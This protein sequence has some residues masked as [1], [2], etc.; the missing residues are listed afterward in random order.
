MNN[1]VWMPIK[2]EVFL[3][4]NTI[5]FKSKIYTDAK[6]RCNKM[7]RGGKIK[8]T[9]N[10]HSIGANERPMLLFVGLNDNTNHPKLHF[11]ISSNGDFSIA[12][13]ELTGWKKLASTEL[14]KIEL[15]HVETAQYDVEIEL[16]GSQACMYINGVLVCKTEQAKST[17]S[18]I[19]LNL[20]GEGKISIQKFDIETKRLSAFVIMDFSEEFEYIYSEVIK[21]V[22]K[23]LDIEC[24]RADEYNYPGSI[25]KDI[26]DSI[27]DSD[28]IIVD[29]TPD[30]PN[31][32]LEVGYA[33]AL[34]KNPILLM[35]KERK[36]LPFDISGFRVIM[37]NNTIKGAPRV[38]MQLKRFLEA[39]I[40]S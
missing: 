39:I 27:R 11:G 3:K 36:K 30:N 38:R 20:E 25:I 13:D 24:Y 31:V 9:V 15:K 14:E 18:Q 10:F 2:G 5:N 26:L 22:C 4:S 23:E 19:T 6:I 28:I 37:Y 7:F 35:N 32:Y 29:I 40:A 34:E 16:I 17:L 8:F 12:Q 21:L 1:L 33:Y